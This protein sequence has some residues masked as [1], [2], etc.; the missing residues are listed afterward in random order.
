[1]KRPALVAGAT[2]ALVAASAAAGQPAPTGPVEFTV[3]PAHSSVQF[4]VRHLGI[5]TVSGRFT[6]FAATFA[7]DPEDPSASWVT[8]TIDASSIDTDHERRD[9]HLRSEDFLWVDRHPT[10][11][12]AGRS[13]E[14]TGENR[15]RISGD[16]TIRGVTR[17]VTVDA[18]LEGATRGRDGVPIV[19]WTAETRIER[20]DYGLVWNRLTEVGSFV[21]GEE[22]RILL[23]VEARGPASESAAS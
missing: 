15:Y 1:M 8:A 22:V 13:V 9:N 23:E 5:S 11:T 20:A 10:I 14:R 17:P 7:Y 3:D 16:L 21:V 12:F 4:K 2:A 6:R 19:A 18:V